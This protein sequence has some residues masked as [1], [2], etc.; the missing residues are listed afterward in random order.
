MYYKF[1]RVGIKFEARQLLQNKSLWFRSFLTIL[2]ALILTNISSQFQT[3]KYIYLIHKYGIKYFLHTLPNA[4]TLY[5]TNLLYSLTFLSIPLLV[6]ISGYFLNI[7]RQ[8][9]P[10][11]SSLYKEGFKNFGKYFLVCSM[12]GIIIGMASMFFLVPGII[13]SL[14]LSQTN[15]IIHDNP[16]L[17]LA[18]VIKISH[19]MTKG[20]KWQIFKMH[21]SF[22]GWILL[23]PFSCGILSI[24]VYPYFEITKAMYYENLKKLSI[25]NGVIAAEAFSP[26]TDIEYMGNFQ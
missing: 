18:Q 15:Y 5:L 19:L 25:E 26:A 7:L 22:I 24:Y 12:C 21:I 11:F 14:V 23:I 13:L 1:N 4:S 6:A 20:Y 16:D 10:N 9:N 17:T 8:K 2:P 3:Y